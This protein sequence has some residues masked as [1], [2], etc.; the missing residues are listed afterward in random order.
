MTK[1]QIYYFFLNMVYI[2]RLFLFL[3]WVKPD[4]SS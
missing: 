3:K 4:A 1:N 2:E